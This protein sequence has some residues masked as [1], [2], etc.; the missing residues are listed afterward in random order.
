MDQLDQ[1]PTIDFLLIADRA[2]VVNGKLYLMG[3]AWD[4]ITITDLSQP[5]TFSVALG[6]LIPWNATNE[7]HRMRLVVEDADGGMLA[8][9]Q[10]ELV[11]GRPPH[12]TAGSPQRVLFAAGVGVLLPRAGTYAIVAYLD[13]EESR[14]SIF[15]ASAGPAQ[16]V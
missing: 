5:V 13:N 4:H 10:G 6:I 3:G 14:R 7:M 9:L 15:N 16:K 8:E 11:A 1:K 12:L 2:E